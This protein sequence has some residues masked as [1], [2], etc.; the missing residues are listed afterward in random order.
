MWLHT[1]IV[2]TPGFHEAMVFGKIL[3]DVLL[4]EGDQYLGYFLKGSS[5]LLFAED[6]S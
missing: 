1:Q 5:L 3:Q 2:P 6:L 4:L